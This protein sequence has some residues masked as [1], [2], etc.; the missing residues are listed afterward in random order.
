MPISAD[1]ITVGS[2]VVDTD[3]D[4][5]LVHRVEDGTAHLYVIRGPNT[6][7]STFDTLCTMHES[8]YYTDKIA[9]IDADELGVFVRIMELVDRDL[10]IRRIHVS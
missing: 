8:E 1:D 6:G 5:S 10:S 4:Y 2:I 7:T 9:Q 3:Y